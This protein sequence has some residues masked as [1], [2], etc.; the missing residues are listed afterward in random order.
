MKLSSLKQVGAAVLVVATIHGCQAS[1]DQAA[2]TEAASSQDPLKA[3]PPGTESEVAAARIQELQRRQENLQF[4]PAIQ[5]LATA[6]IEADPEFALAWLYRAYQ[7]PP[8]MEALAKAEELAQNAPDSHRRYIELQATTFKDPSTAP[9]IAA[10]APLTELAEEYPGE[11]MLWMVI[12]QY[13][14]M[15]GRTADAR[16]S[17]ARALALDD[18]TPRVHAALAGTLIL[19]GEYAEARGALEKALAKVPADATPVNIHYQVAFTHL[20]EGDV[21]A[22][23]ERLT[24]LAADYEQAGRP[25]GIPEVFI[26]NSIA[27]VNLEN[28][29]LEEA[30]K[31]YERGYES[32]PDSDLDETQKK[33]WYGRLLHGKSRTLAR[34]GQ[35]GEAWKNVVAVRQMIDEGG[36]EAEQFEPAYHYLAGYCKLEAG[37]YDAAIEHLEQS[38][39]GDPFQRLLLARAYE[40][41]GQ[42]AEARRTYEEVTVSRTNNIER[43]LAYPEA[44]RKLKAG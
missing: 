17:Y 34:M 15:D 23:L 21:D 32:V 27:R 5:E 26:W 19:D 40:K 8:D 41:A 39:P 43:A 29:R 33:I 18:S 25:F 2:T 20:Y 37:E 30:M 28:G 7:F 44:Q 38:N 3:F 35:H 9:N 36:E 1:S 12:G 14:Q 11:R 31:A 13:Q 10:I 24:Q 22:A 42:S 16:A 4:G 6:A